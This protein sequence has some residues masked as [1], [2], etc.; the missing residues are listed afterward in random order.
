MPCIQTSV[1]LI[2]RCYPLDLGVP[3]LSLILVVI[4]PVRSDLSS[5][6]EQVYLLRLEVHGTLYDPTAWKFLMS[7]PHRAP[8]RYLAV[9]MAMLKLVRGGH[10]CSVAGGDDSTLDLNL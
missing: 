10:Y 7:Q 6:Q 4:N 8:V 2:R 9:R 3:V 1:S 5:I